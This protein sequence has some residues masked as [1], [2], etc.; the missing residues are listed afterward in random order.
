[1]VATQSV[2]VLAA[3]IARDWPQPFRLE[4]NFLEIGISIRK[5]SSR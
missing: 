1:L 5:D 2:A 4:L 3:L